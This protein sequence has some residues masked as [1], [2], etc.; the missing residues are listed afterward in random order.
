[1]ALEPEPVLGLELALGLE[2]APVLE[3][4]PGPGLEPARELEPE[5]AREPVLAREPEPVLEQARVRVAA[6]AAE[7]KALAARAVVAEEDCY[8]RAAPFGQP[9]SS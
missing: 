1:V 7:K 2:P 3:P 8:L 4:G 5:L 6:V 9:A